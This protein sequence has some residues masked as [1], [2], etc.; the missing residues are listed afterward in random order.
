MVYPEKIEINIIDM[1][2]IHVAS[3]LCWIKLFL[4]HI[5]QGQMVIVFGHH[6]I[7]T[8]GFLH[9]PGSE[10]LQQDILPLLRQY[11]VE[12]YLGKLLVL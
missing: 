8:S 7:Y 11:Q 3:A 4:C 5:R 6:P 12:F 2:D 9:G 1:T 10:A